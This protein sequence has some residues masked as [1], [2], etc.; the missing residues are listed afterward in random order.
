MNE[1]P[2]KMTALERQMY[3]AR[4]REIMA[5]PSYILKIQ[6]GIESLNKKIDKLLK[7]MENAS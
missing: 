1:W 6:D 2:T 3:E 4:Q 7:L 5:T